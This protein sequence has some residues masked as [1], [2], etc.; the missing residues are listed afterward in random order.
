[1]KKYPSIEYKDNGFFEIKHE[2]VSA[3]L[4]WDGKISITTDECEE[5][6]EGEKDFPIF[7][8]NEESSNTIKELL[9]F[10]RE[11]RFAFHIVSCWEEKKVNFMKEG[12]KYL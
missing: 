4:Y 10:V 2:N 5:F 12:A 8:M 11:L 3:Q 6:F 9:E 1:M 7:I